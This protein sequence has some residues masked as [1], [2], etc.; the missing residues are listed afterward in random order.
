MAGSLLAVVALGLMNGTPNSSPRWY[1]G[2]AI[3][4]A[5]CLAYLVEEMVWMAR[6]QGRPCAK[7]GRGLRVK[8]FRLHLRCPHC[9]EM[10]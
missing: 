10:Q 6:N 5:L 3:T 9:G 2:G 4:V 8:P 1:V 7:C